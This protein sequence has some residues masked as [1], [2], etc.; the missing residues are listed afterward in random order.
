MPRVSEF[1]KTLEVLAVGEAPVHARLESRALPEEDLEDGLDPDQL[2]VDLKRAAPEVYRSIITAGNTSLTGYL[3]DIFPAAS[4]DNSAD[5]LYFFNGL[6]SIDFAMKGKSTQEKLEWLAESDPA[7]LTLRHLSSFIHYKRTGDKD[8][9]QA[10]LALQPAG[11]KTDIA[12]NWLL[13]E[14]GLHANYEHQ[15]RER[16]RGQTWKGDRSGKG[17]G[18]KADGKKDKKGKKGDKWQGATSGWQLNHCG[19]GRSQTGWTPDGE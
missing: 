17:G 11:S 13:Q 9:A 8:A 10:M 15:R 3:N 5:Y 7:K 16:A 18:G 1:Q 14:A 12:P 4:R 6:R 2:P 19:S